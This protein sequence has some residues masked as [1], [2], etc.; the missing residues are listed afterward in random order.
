MTVRE[1]D[2]MLVQ[3][4]EVAV[5]DSAFDTSMTRTGDSERPHLTTH[6]I[7]AALIGVACGIV[8]GTFIGWMWRAA[9]AEERR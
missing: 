1:R 6:L 5:C 8:S 7:T 4:K 3:R 9:V 2:G